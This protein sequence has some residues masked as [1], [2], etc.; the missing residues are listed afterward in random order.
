MCFPQ[1]LIEP[2]FYESK[3]HLAQRVYRTIEY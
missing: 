3:D 1:K 2:P